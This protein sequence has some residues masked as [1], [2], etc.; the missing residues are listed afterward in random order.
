M[1]CKNCGFDNGSSEKY[2]VKCGKVLN[3]A[4]N[5]NFER[6][7]D[8]SK[9]D[10]VDLSQIEKR[11]IK[12][13]D[14]WDSVM[15]GN[16]K[17]PVLLDKE[18]TTSEKKENLKT[19]QRRASTPIR[20]Q[21]DRV[22][23]TKTNENGSNDLAN[24]NMISILFAIVF[25]LALIFVYLI[26][27]PTDNSLK[28]KYSATI[29]ANDT[30]SD[31]YY[32][33][34]YGSAGDTAVFR[35]SSY[36]TTQLEITSKGY[37]VFNVYGKDLLP[38]APIDD[39]QLEVTPTVA[40]VKKGTDTPL[41]IGVN[42][43]TIPVPEF[44]IV[45]DHEQK[46]AQQGQSEEIGEQKVI[47]ANTIECFEGKITISG[48]VPMNAVSIKCD[49]N[50]VD[51][52]DNLFSYSMQFVSK[53]EF[54][55]KFEASL[56]GYRTIKRTFTAIV[57]NDLAVEQIIFI[58]DDFQTR[59]SNETEEMEIYGTV[60]K[61]TTLSIA[62]DDTDLVLKSE[63]VVDEE[64]NFTFTVGLPVA[65]KNY[66]MLINATLADGKV[67]SR[68]F[69]VQRPPLF[70]EYIPTLW[71]CHYSDM[72]KPNYFGVKGFVINGRLTEIISNNDY[73][74]ARLS[75]TDGNDIN[76]CYYNH[77]AGATVLEEDNTY[78]MYGYPVCINEDGILEVFIWFVKD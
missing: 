2:C 25:F 72:I 30:N 47:D 53:G 9:F 68:S 6:T 57:R 29:S 40:I 67:V 22:E 66:N 45:F 1:K 17:G 33:T 7:K 24:K 19:T 18:R 71:A 76:I 60:P 50:E 35:S 31:T 51:L 65:S 38:V 59:V 56:P 27:S 34:V 8:S 3:E 41:S 42:S 58:D 37:V 5:S 15:N 36:E 62:T 39:E 23:Q 12:D 46:L 73:L 70:N 52:Q 13:A 61:G 43:I 48:K 21:N 11:F 32:L 49:D 55:I 16:K 28:Y 63:P 69:A 4:N 77:Y 26:I 14:S 78:T 75:L 64:G 20:K 44:N 10:D 54:Q 74:Y